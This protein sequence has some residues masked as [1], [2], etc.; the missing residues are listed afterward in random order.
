M[1]LKLKKIV[2]I[3]TIT[4]IFT[5]EPLS[6]FHFPEDDDTQFGVRASR[7]D[8]K[9][10]ELQIPQA[11]EDEKIPTLNQTGFMTPDQNPFNN[12][13]I[14]FAATSNH[15][16]LDVGAAYGL[17]SLPALQKGALVI[18]NDI[19]PRHLL[20]LR[21]HVEEQ[22][23]NRLFLNTKRFPNETDFPDQ[24]IGAILLC[25]I[26][27][28]L[29]GEEMDQAIEKMTKW[30]VPGGRIFVITM[31][32]HHHLLT[33]FLPTYQQKAEEQIPWPGVINNMHEIAPDLKSQ[34]P[35]FLH[36]MDR[37]SLGKAFERH[38]FKII[39]DSLFDYTRAK[40]KKSDGK[41]YYGIIVEKN[42]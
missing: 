5:S 8:L 24:S 11:E 19:D 35:N 3:M 26:V 15:P 2:F 16:V 21:E 31:S 10:G 18:A 30:L 39:E 27:H 29:N 37:Q 36:V 14:D 23:R 38:G 1:H 9:V 7:S 41:G 32:A 20:L 17:T 12:S 6:A 22:S 33:S 25:R 40:A 13:F 4:A 28:F 34:I 42:K